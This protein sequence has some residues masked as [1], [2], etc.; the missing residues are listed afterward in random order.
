MAVLEGV[1][2]LL[3]SLNACVS[4]FLGQN[5]VLF[6]AVRVQGAKAMQYDFFGRS[7]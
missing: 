5:Q 1:F 6:T 2:L 3:W 4:V 7:R